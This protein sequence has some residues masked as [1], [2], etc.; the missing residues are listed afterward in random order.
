MGQSFL[1]RTGSCRGQLIISRRADIGEGKVR[2]KGKYKTWT[3][4]SMLQAA[5]LCLINRI[6]LCC[7]FNDSSSWS[8]HLES[9]NL[10]EVVF[11]LKYLNLV[12]S[13]WASLL[14]FYRGR[15]SPVWCKERHQLRFLCLASLSGWTLQPVISLQTLSCWIT[16]L[17]NTFPSFQV[18][19]IHH[20]KVVSCRNFW[21]LNVCTKV[22]ASMAQLLMERLQKNC[23]TL[24]DVPCQCQCQMKHH[25]S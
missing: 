2:G 24:Q 4:E 3:P 1:L 22:R 19:N 17:T 7:F 5:F 10:E 20:L 18:M 9:R 25:P 16:W 23:K 14:K 11:F 6:F 8:W 15:L 13:G 12:S 21:W